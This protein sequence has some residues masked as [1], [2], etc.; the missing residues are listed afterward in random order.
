MKKEILVLGGGVTGLAAGFVGGF[1]IYEKRRVPGGICSSYY[2]Q[3]YRF[4]IGGGHWI[5]DGNRFPQAR[6]FIAQF[7]PLKSYFRQA[8]IYFNESNNGAVLIPYPIQNNLSYLP[9]DV[10]ALVLS[11]ITAPK[12]NPT[13]TATLE[14]WLCNTFGMT[15]YRLFF[16]P[17][18]DKYIIGLQNQVVAQDM[19]KSP[20]N[21]EHVMNGAYYRQEKSLE[22]VGYNPTYLYPTQGLDHLILQMAKKCQIIYEKEAIKID[23]NNKL[24]Y[25]ADGDR[26][27]YKTLIST[28]PLNIMLNLTGLNVRD[29]EPPY[30]SVLVLNIGAEKGA[31]CPTEHWLYIPE[32]G[33]TFH[34]VGFYSNVDLSFSPSSEE[35]VAIY[36]E[37]SFMS[38]SKPNQGEIEQ[39]T[40][41]VIQTLQNWQFIKRVEV[42]NTNWVE[43]AYTLNLPKS[44]WREQ[45]IRTLNEHSICQV[46]RYGRWKFQGILQSLRDGIFVGTQ[47]SNRRIHPFTS[48]LER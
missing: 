41:D 39:Y 42:I 47:L 6:D 15:L 45:A 1:P 37:R 48:E 3:G 10:C 33:F 12:Q 25:F 16:K 34:R 8:G 4:E 36:V 18:H 27:R 40:S 13:S 5:F 22:I 21:I 20:I 32:S 9:S 38:N 7:T 26:Q 17:F 29:A 23:I 46:G 19:Y 24:V 43:T 30:V 44:R 28:L 2:L 31:L 35:K 11:E 14:Q